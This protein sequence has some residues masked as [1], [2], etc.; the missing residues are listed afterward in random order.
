MEQADFRNAMARMA[1]AVKVVTSDGSAGRTGFTATA[2]CSVTDT[3]PRLL[4][5]LNG[6][7]SSHPFVTGNGRFCVNVLPERTE[8]VATGFGG[9]LPREER[10]DRGSWSR[11]EN[12]QWA[13]DG[14]I[15]SFDCV[16]AETCESGSHT[17]FIADVVGCRVADGGRPLIYA[18]RVFTTTATEPENA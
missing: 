3:P 10:F 4:V 15:A 1:A 18:D 6:G 14:A 2:V 12:G 16:I 7:S 8:D 9:A 11:T 17:I 13:L 5:C